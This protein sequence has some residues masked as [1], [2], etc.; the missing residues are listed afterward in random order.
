MGISSVFEAAAEPKR[1]T[2][3][4]GLLSVPIRLSAILLAAPAAIEKRTTQK[5]QTAQ[6]QHIGQRGKTLLGRHLSA[7]AAK[8]TRPP[9]LIEK[10]KKEERK[11]IEEKSAVRSD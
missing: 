5:V 10:R 7:D 3:S 8:P 1:D 4:L 11:K 2:Q 9:I 6:R